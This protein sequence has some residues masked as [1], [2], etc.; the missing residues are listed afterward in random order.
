MKKDYREEVKE[1][2]SRNKKD[3]KTQMEVLKFLDI[4]WF[5]II[6]KP[7][8]DNIIRQLQ[9]S[10]LSIVWLSLNKDNIDLKNWNFWESG[11]LRDTDKWMNIEAKR[12]LIKFMNKLLSWNVDEPLLVEALA[13]NRM[14]MSKIDMKEK[15]REAWIVD[16]VSWKIGKMK[17]NLG[18]REL[19]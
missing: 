12:N 15:F 4:S 1:L 17:E 3:K 8:T 11:V 10:S 7:I 14:I 16:N 9:T 18:K 2:L 19:I 5:D 6:P 13:S